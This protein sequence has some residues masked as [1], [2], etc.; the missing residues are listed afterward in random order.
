M[1]QANSIFKIGQ[2]YS[3]NDIVL[4]LEAFKQ[5]AYEAIKSVWNDNFQ[6][7]VPTSTPP[8]SWVITL[9]RKGPGVMFF[10]NNQNE[11]NFQTALNNAVG[12]EVLQVLVD[13]NW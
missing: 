4:A 6:R 13:K 3:E 5:K 11:D 12:R 8:G 9:Q 7:E 1:R 2:S 10:I